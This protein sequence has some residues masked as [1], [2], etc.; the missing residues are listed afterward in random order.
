MVEVAEAIERV[1]EATAGRRRDD[2]RAAGKNRRV[3]SLVAVC[4]EDV[5]ALCDACV[6]P[7]QKVQD[8]RMGSA[9]GKP[10][11]EVAIKVIDA[12]HLVEQAEKGLAAAAEAAAAERA[13]ELAAKD[14]PP[15][16]ANED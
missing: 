1:R 14:V 2:K 5:L 3:V 12:D 10:E 6:N 11:R 8:L 16:V 15:A 4:A 13:A 9:A 7:D